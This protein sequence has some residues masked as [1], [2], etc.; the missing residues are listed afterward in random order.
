MSA[1]YAS[2][3][4]VLTITTIISMIKPHF[5]RYIVNKFAYVPHNHTIRHMELH[6]HAADTLMPFNQQEVNG[7]ATALSV[8]SLPRAFVGG[9]YAGV[10]MST[11]NLHKLK[12]MKTTYLHTKPPFKG[13]FWCTPRHRGA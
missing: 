10:N 1:L 3:V 13:R 6:C 8:L 11:P 2:L 12:L 5:F 9:F 7:L 4:S